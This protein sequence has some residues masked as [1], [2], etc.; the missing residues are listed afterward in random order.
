MPA[1]SRALAAAN[2]LDHRARAVAAAARW[3]QAGR[4]LDLQGLADELGISRATLFRQAGTR[5]L[6]L[7][8]ALWHQTHRT[9]QAAARRAEA[10]RGPDE[11]RG[12]LVARHMNALVSRSTALRRLLDDE[13]ALAI[14]V[15]TDPTG[16][17][18][19]RVVRFIE[20]VLHQDMA[21]GYQ[22][23]IAPADLAYALVRL[24]ESFLY[25]DVL[26]DR[27]PDVAVA[28]RLQQALLQ[29]THTA[30][31]S[32]STQPAHVNVGCAG[33]ACSHPP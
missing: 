2:L 27:H 15:L 6:L 29:A 7:G 17:V 4:R 32:T 10:L 8:E 19:P 25:A 22:P 11:F 33:T 24:G 30:P 26:A 9:L 13:P 16:P 20:A 12:V 5:D 31:L 14:R 21:D 23:V 1:P 3:V 18:Q 28:D